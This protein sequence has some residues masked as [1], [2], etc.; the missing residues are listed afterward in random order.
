MKIK[1]N[2]TLIVSGRDIQNIVRNYG[3]NVIM[4]RLIA[5][6]AVAIKN[7]DPGRTSIPV[8]SGFNYES[9]RSGLVEWMPVYNHGENVLIKLVGYHPANPQEYDLPTIIS[10]ISVYDTETG[11]L[12]SIMGGGLATAFRTG[13]ASAVAS[14]ALAHPDSSTLGLIGCGTQ[15]VTQ[16]HALSRIFDLKQILIFDA[17]PKTM[18]SFKE[19]I[20]SLDLNVEI[21]RSDIAG[22]VQNSDI[23]CTATSIDVG[24]G[25][26]FSGL[27]TKSHLHINAVGSDFPG[28]IEIPLDILQKSFICPDFIE[29]AVVEGECQQLKRE[30]INADLAEIVRNADSFVSIQNELS[31]FDSTGWALE[32]QVTAEVFLEYAFELGLGQE[33]EIETMF[34]DVKNPYH[35]LQETVIP[36]EV[37][38]EN[39]RKEIN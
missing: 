10:T 34:G 20:D 4:D 37:E 24:A 38:S 2:K 15:A 21:I 35:F 5:R 36:I 3:L 6:L 31:V 25:P 1:S 18:A 9:P 26:L 16:L 12:S 30:A 32:D 29:Q 33:V 39:L 14:R 28:K 23:L 13:A 17:D 19:R 11:H 22:I 8:R 27:K 7:F